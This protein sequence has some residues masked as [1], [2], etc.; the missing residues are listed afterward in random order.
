L[1]EAGRLARHRTSKQ[2][3]EALRAAI[4]RNLKDAGLAGL[5][6]DNR[7]GLAYE[8]ALL[9]ARLAVHAAGYRVKPLPGAHRTTFEALGLA[10]GAAHQDRVDY[11]ELCRRRRNELSY[12]AANVV[13]ARQATEILKEARELIL[14]VEQWVRSHHAH[15]AK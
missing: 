5:S 4:E 10:L 8:A 3:A 7:F 9:A 2:E 15:L 12:E 13:T 14:S 1:L 6:A 11:F